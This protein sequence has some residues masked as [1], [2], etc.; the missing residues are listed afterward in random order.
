MN[1]SL[2]PPKTFVPKRHNFSIPKNLSEKIIRLR[3]PAQFKNPATHS[4]RSDYGISEAAN[5]SDPAAGQKE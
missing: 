1:L 3:T 2:H 5:V 4:Q